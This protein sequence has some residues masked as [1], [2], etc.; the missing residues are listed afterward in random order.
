MRRD[1]ERANGAPVRAA[2]NSDQ[3]SVLVTRR[4]VVGGLGAAAVLASHALGALEPLDISRDKGAVL[5]RLGAR[6]PWRIEPFEYGDR[7]SLAIRPDN[8]GAINRL[9]TL[10]QAQ[11]PGGAAW[12]MSIE[13]LADGDT[14]RMRIQVNAFLAKKTSLT[15]VALARFLDG[16]ELP[17]ATLKPVEASKFIKRYFGER[18]ALG[19]PLEVLFDK[20]GVWR[21]RAS[22]PSLTMMSGTANIEKLSVRR[23]QGTHGDLADIQKTD[24]PNATRTALI[25]TGQTLAAPSEIVLGYKGDAKITVQAHE[26][27][28]V[29]LRQWGT[30][31]RTVAA[32]VWPAPELPD[33]AKRSQFQLYLTQD[34]I[35]EGPFELA[36]GR[37]LRQD[38]GA[39]I[40][41]RIEGTLTEKEVRVTT[42]MGGFD[43]AGL[44]TGGAA[45]PTPRVTAELPSQILRNFAA[46]GLLS[47]A[48]AVLPHQSL[49]PNGSD[50]GVTSRLDFDGTECLFGAG[51]T[52]QGSAAAFIRLGRP[53][54]GTHW[55]L[56]P[57]NIALDRARLRV[58]RPD[59][60]LSLVFR[61][62][63]L[64]LQMLPE[65]GQIVPTSHAGTCTL[66]STTPA[67]GGAPTLADDR[68][69]LVVE[70]PPQHVAERAYFRQLNYDLPDPSLTDDQIAQVRDTSPPARVH[71]RMM[72]AA[73][74]LA[75]P[76]PPTPQC[77]QPP[78]PRKDFREFSNF[79]NTLSRIE[80]V[81]QL[82]ADG[83][84][85]IKRWLS[86][87]KDQQVYLGP[88]PQV[89]DADAHGVARQI[90]VAW[91]AQ[92]LKGTPDF[93]TTYL[94]RLP[95]VSLPTY[96]RTSLKTQE[97]VE[98][99]KARR[100]YD[101]KQFQSLYEAEAG[102]LPSRLQVF[103]GGVWYAELSPPDQMLVQAPL[104]KVFKSLDNP[105]PDP[106][107]F[108]TITQ[109][110]LA[111]V[112]RL[113]FRV[114]CKSQ[115]R[116]DKDP[117][118]E[119][120][121]DPI[122]F[123]LDGLTDWSNH[124]LAVV[125]RA[126]TLYKLED[127]V[128]PP[129]PWRTAE[130]DDAKILIYQGITPGDSIDQRLED[131]RRTS[132]AC[133]GEF[134]TAIEM[135]FRLVLSPSQ[136][137]NFRSPHIVPHDLFDDAL[138]G[139]P[140]AAGPIPRR[141]WSVELDQ[142]ASASDVRAVWSPDFEPGVFARAGRIPPPNRG[143]FA[144][145]NLVRGSVPD[146][147]REP[148]RA[149]MDAYDRH[150]LVALTSVYGM[151]VL[152]RRN[153]RF[154]LTDGSQFEPPEGYA[155]KGLQEFPD[156]P[157]KL[158]QSAIYRPE[159]LKVSELRLT[160]LGGS[161]DIDTSFVPPASA[162]DA[163]L[164]D[165]FPSLSIERWRHR[166]VLGRDIL[167]EIVYKGFLFPLGM[168]CSLV[169]LTERRFFKHPRTQAPTAFLIQR[170]FLRIGRP[171]KN[172]PALGQPNRGSRFPCEVVTFLTRRTPDIVDPMPQG[173]FE[174]KQTQ[175]R[176]GTN[177][178]L[179]FLDLPKNP[180]LVFWPRT[181]LDPRADVQFQFEIDR[182][183]GAVSMPLIF[184]DNTA[185]ND[186]AIMSALVAYYNSLPDQPPN[187]T[188][189]LHY[190]VP[191]RYAPEFNPGDTKHET[192]SWLLKA[193]GRQ[194]NLPAVNAVDDSIT[195][196]N[197]DY[198][199][200]ALL[201]GADQPPFYPWIH[202]AEIRL[203]AA[204]RFIGQPLERARVR[205]NSAYVQSGFTKDSDT[206]LALVDTVAL[207]MGSSGDRSSGLTRIGMDISGVDRRIGLV[208]GA[209]TAP[210]APGG[211]APPV[212]LPSVKFNAASLFNGDAKFLGIV[213]ISKLF[214]DLL[215]SLGVADAPAL[216]ELVSYAVDGV[217]QTAESMCTLVVV[218]LSQRVGEIKSRWDKA[219][220]G[221]S[222]PADGTVDLNTLYPDIAPALMRLDDELRGAKEA[223]SNPGPNA[224]KIAA[225][226]GRIYEAGRSF[227][228]A[229]DRVA[230]DP[231]APLRVQANQL[232][233]DKVGQIQSLLQSGLQDA[234][235]LLKQRATAA[236]NSLKTT[237]FKLV[238]G[239]IVALPVPPAAVPNAFIHQVDD[240]LVGA[241]VSYLAAFA[242]SEKPPPLKT[243]TNQLEA[244]LRAAAK[245]ATDAALTTA[246][247]N[248]A[249]TVHGMADQRIDQFQGILYD[250]LFGK[251]GLVADSLTAWTKVANELSDAGLD[252]LQITMQALGGVIVAIARL[253]TIAEIKVEGLCQDAAQGMLGFATAL[254]ANL[255]V[256]AIKSALDGFSG[257]FR[258]HAPAVWLPAA[259]RLDQTVKAVEEAAAQ[260]QSAQKQLADA[261][262]A[263]PADA[264][265]GLI[266]LPGDVVMPA[267]LAGKN[268]AT[269]IADLTARLASPGL[270]LPADVAV[271]PPP[272]AWWNAITGADADDVRDA[273][274]TAA[275]SITTTLRAVTAT[276]LGTD[277]APSV[278]VIRSTLAAARGTLTSPLAMD[279]IN[280]S[281]K[282]AEDA[283]N[284][285]QGAL[286]EIDAAL[287]QADDAL[288]AATTLAGM[289]GAV[290]DQLVAVV[291]DA[292]IKRLMN[293][294]EKPITTWCAQAMAIQDPV[295]TVILASAA[296]LGR[297]IFSGLKVLYDGVNRPRSEALKQLKQLGPVV[298][299]LVGPKVDQIFLVNPKDPP[300]P[301]TDAVAD[302]KVLVDDVARE[303][304]D[305]QFVSKVEKLAQQWIPPG[306][307]ALAVL[308]QQVQQAAVT[309]LK[310]D[311][312]QFIDVQ[313][314]RAEVEKQI[315]SMVPS[316]IS[317]KY[318]LAFRVGEGLPA[319]LKFDNPDEK[320][321]INAHGEIDLLNGN[322]QPQFSVD[323]SVPRF[324]V[325]LLPCFDVATMHF[326][327]ATFQ[328]GTGRSTN[329]K[330]D[331]ERIELGKEVAFIQEIQNFIGAP[332]DGNG[333]YIAPSTERLGI[334]AGYRLAL[335]PF[336]IGDVGF[337]HVSL[338]CS[339]D[340]PFDSGDARFLISIGRPDSPLL[341]A[342]A[343]YAGAGYIG[344]IANA[345]GIVGFE[346]SLEFGGG[347][348]FAFGPLQGEGRITVGI[349]IRQISG[350]TTLYGTF[351]VGGSARIACFSCSSSFNVRLSQQPGG[352][353]E[354][355]AVYSFSFSFGIGSVDFSIAVWKSQSNG[356]GQQSASLFDNNRIR[357]AQAGSHSLTDA[358]ATAPAVCK[359]QSVDVLS[360]KAVCQGV[361]WSTYASY[362][363]TPEVAVFA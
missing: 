13:F 175:C 14:W 191:R 30:P 213:E 94:S 28:Q 41:E 113:A 305:A 51:A 204:E 127:D 57:I 202:V 275:K 363:E 276:G 330:L 18:V 55:N 120:T 90:L 145:W 144:P 358:G 35:A 12:D 263:L 68:P 96:V 237:E 172:Y 361:N 227:V 196:D 220:K 193:E 352:S 107:A 134:E 2:T 234:S 100:D 26:R 131:I 83:P 138:S 177:G 292:I 69:I 165:L 264:C 259:D 98:D 316:K 283:L 46:R 163:G 334:V 321:E 86:L 135:P 293:D 114:N 130:G 72:L 60:L 326:K 314:A 244:S 186:T 169:K 236:L 3:S 45:L 48:T 153:D 286:M 23:V 19:G 267:L 255:D 290:K 308:G 351:Y 262:R 299:K 279:I 231:I 125:R 228:A 167:V 62:S 74:L 277:I 313:A 242:A 296:S 63:G 272:W 302:E 245:A 355:S 342:A 27:A 77:P 151:P 39:G 325:K 311:I 362:F 218:P 140:R 49:S 81:G 88:D 36:S 261:V 20:G 249:S 128:L 198:T 11:W 309:F 251:G 122:P 306:S 109:A 294:L 301:D 274:Q 54:T 148:F 268:L 339:C 7:A 270:V 66:T 226:L 269:K 91:K 176:L 298:T 162:R 209:K 208:G 78:D 157:Q 61:F 44:A 102:A 1:D 215:Q 160:A 303:V 156:Y 142:I 34:Q 105:D 108:E 181:A 179:A 174:G 155:L 71:A 50:G 211:P 329:F 132:D 289:A 310:G 158:D 317:T 80:P 240:A 164:N 42:R 104:R 79:L 345:K 21:I 101:Y 257:S 184:V 6:E 118:A 187:R 212:S 38:T 75:L 222:G 281:I 297:P 141:L 265:V 332:K 147:E 183:A 116:D 223:C 307:P 241:L 252:A 171:E 233:R 124:D 16:R 340:L 53:V 346:A 295:R 318:D 59:D 239:L 195:L 327:P 106:E 188:K 285:I 89:M 315:K 159:P 235:N 246:L 219:V 190:G 111:G 82:G 95:D 31:A 229:L 168:R 117:D 166:A 284:S 22:S 119:K 250:R 192:I 336:T 52:T 258:S 319:L 24:A 143:P 85:L 359:P 323:G 216:Q 221:V 87:P 343:P 73:Q 278:M 248:Y 97:A 256:D 136:S 200:D 15:V 112:S 288:D 205:F 282:P 9:V 84:R 356:G 47:H 17:R 349:F 217:E 29:A 182:A 341:I 126:E 8:A 348:V 4:E 37:I 139:D 260:F 254:T 146:A 335:N 338:N 271:A 324:Q 129:R 232:F 178:H 300:S 344:L 287:K 180:G 201:E 67:A 70:F 210:T 354:G 10:K 115:Y 76:S 280:T 350:Y 110:R 357:Y 185:A 206:Y 224:G 152:G 43:I 189:L 337:S 137:A 225:D 40:T 58:T 266:A 197:S 347:G 149:S 253:A 214:Q 99:E 154:V 92:Q 5:V 64:T 247:N 133:P 25:A 353:L 203:T 32:L 322:H 33:A 331:I 291:A 238:R 65:R 173:T 123:T 243:L 93:D 273:L 333:F 170:M 230:A 328:A 312:G 320:L 304:N 194:R 150:E 360:N 103:R 56:A 199:H 121:A 161:L 207:Q